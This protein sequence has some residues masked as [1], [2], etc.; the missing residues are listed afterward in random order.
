VISPQEGAILNKLPRDEI[1]AISKHSVAAGYS[2]KPD[3]LRAKWMS[4]WQSATVEN[5]D[6][7]LQIGWLPAGNSGGS[8]RCGRG[9]GG[10]GFDGDGCGMDHAFMIGF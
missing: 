9:F 10:V 6:F 5:L 8:E 4:E 3:S 2:V 7:D 1:C